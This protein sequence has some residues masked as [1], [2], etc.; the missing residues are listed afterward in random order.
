MGERLSTLVD[1]MKGLGKAVGVCIY[2]G[3]VPFS[4]LHLIK[5]PHHFGGP[6][7]SAPMKKGRNGAL[8][9]AEGLK[10]GTYLVMYHAME[11][12]GAI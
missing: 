11:V 6:N 12:H 1:G 5:Y 8:W 9:L 2:L 3:T 7:A 4:S 10:I